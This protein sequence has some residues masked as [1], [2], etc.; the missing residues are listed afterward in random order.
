MHAFYFDLLKIKEFELYLS[1]TKSGVESVLSYAYDH[2][3]KRMLA[4]H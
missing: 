2:L 4:N 3:K 1:T